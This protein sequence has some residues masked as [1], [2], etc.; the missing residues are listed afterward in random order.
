MSLRRAAKRDAVEAEIVDTLRACGW[1]IHY[2]SARNAPDL[3]AGKHGLNLLIEVKSGTKKLRPG[4]ADWHRDWRGGTPYVLRSVA[5][6]LTLNRAAGK[7]K[8]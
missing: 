8:R 7:A 5:D 4:Q 3:L 6:A 2:M 1:S